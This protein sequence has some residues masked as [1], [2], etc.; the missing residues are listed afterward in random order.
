MKSQ[1]GLRAL[2]PLLDPTRQALYAYVAGSDHPV[3]R[4]EAA[5]ATGVGRPLA[6]FH[7]DK[8]VG[9]GLLR[10]ERTPA[11]VARGRGRPPKLYGRA[12]LDV[13]ISVPARS[14][15]LA[16]RILGRAVAARWR[17]MKGEVGAHA[18]EAGVSAG[19]AV[20]RRLGASPSRRRIATA[21]QRELEDLGYAPVRE[22]D[23]LRLRNCPFHALAEEQRTEICHLNRSFLQGLAGELPGDAAA[24]PEEERSASACCAALRLVV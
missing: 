17:V 16:G 20:L 14:Y 13:E 10:V 5:A 18:R 12:G 8:L 21:V 19:R 15:G 2:A 11:N 22:G 3:G 4:D 6:A 7:L 1:D 24:L 9:A 23:L